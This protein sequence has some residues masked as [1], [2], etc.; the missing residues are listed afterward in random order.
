MP[1]LSWL[2]SRPA[3]ALYGLVL[4]V[5]LGL[6]YARLAGPIRAKDIAFALGDLDAGIGTATPVTQRDLNRELAAMAADGG[7]DPRGWAREHGAHVD[8]VTRGQF[9]RKQDVPGVFTF[10]GCGA[11]VGPPRPSGTADDRS[12]YSKSMPSGEF[13]T[14]SVANSDPVP[15]HWQDTHHRFA[16]DVPDLR[17]PAESA[18][19]HASQ[20]FDVTVVSLA[21][22]GSP[23]R[24]QQ[25]TVREVDPETGEDLGDAKVRSLRSDYVPAPP[26]PSTRVGLLLALNL[27]G[28]SQ[29]QSAFGGPLSWGVIAER[30][31]WQRVWAGGF[32]LSSGQVGGSLQLELP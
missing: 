15:L 27:P 22:D 18:R 1:L 8:G 14:A 19:F 11:E 16:L 25:V 32:L 30:R 3:C 6:W 12:N 29:P 20:L 9:E 26:P 31:V 21:S 5:L 10:G 2:A 7:P 17:G 13:A 24:N 28:L 23:L 4:G